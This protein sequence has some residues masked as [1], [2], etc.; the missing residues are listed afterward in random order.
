MTGDKQ[1]PA[2]APPFPFPKSSPEQ[3]KPDQPQ[4]PEAEPDQPE[5]LSA[6]DLRLMADT[7][8]GDGPGD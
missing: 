6:E 8:P 2:V 7:M 5:E 3:D 4:A 1:K